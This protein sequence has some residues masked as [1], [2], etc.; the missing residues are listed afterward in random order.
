MPTP[1]EAI[2]GVPNAHQALDTVLTGGQPS[3]AH[4][5]GMKEAGVQVILDIRDPMEPRSFD[6]PRLVRSLGLEYF[7]V[8]MTPATL[9]DET[10]AQ[11]L[12]VLR[13]NQGRQLLFHCQSGNRVGGPMIAFL[14]LD[15][16]LS[17][18]EAIAAAMRVGLRSA[19][20]VDWA[21]DYVRRNSG[22]G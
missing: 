4:F 11:I 8:P 6:E 5:Q 7:N 14:M 18:E 9:T 19:E 13:G 1:L 21:L 3:A 17:Q 2:A 15:W 16:G 22:E 20:Y 10:M 12:G